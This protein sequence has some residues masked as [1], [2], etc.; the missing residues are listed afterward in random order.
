MADELFTIPATFWKK[1][2]YAEMDAIFFQSDGRLSPKQIKLL[3]KEMRRTDKPPAGFQLDLDAL[4]PA[5]QSHF[6]LLRQVS[7]SLGVGPLPNVDDRT[8]RRMLGMPPK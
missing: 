3:W 6:Q 5:F 1:L 7:K 2:S 4:P 8:M